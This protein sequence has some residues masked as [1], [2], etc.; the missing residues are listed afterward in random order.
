M[1]NSTPA[2]KTAVLALAVLLPMTGCTGGRD[3]W[4]E[5]PGP[6][7]LAYFPPLYSL[8]ATVAG[9][10]AQVMSLITH[11]GPHHFEPTMRDARC[12]TRADLFLTVGLGL[13]D[14]VSR[15]L[16]DT[17]GNSKLKLV[18][19]GETLPRDS[20]REGGCNCEHGHDHGDHGHYDPHVWLGIP[21]AKRM[22]LAIANELA[23]I[24][25][26]HAAGYRSRA[27]ALAGRLDRLQA[28]GKALLAAKKE[29]PKLLSFHDSLFYFARSFDVEV[30]DSIEAPGQ[31]P[32][33]RKVAQLVETCKK[34]GVRLIAVEPQYPTHTSAR[35]I[36]DALKAAGV[37]AAFVVI[38]PL[39]TADAADLTPDFYERTM[40]GN[41]ERL[42][43]ALQ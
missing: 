35:V 7:V 21:E 14:A 42:A 24:D 43:G 10:D 3:P 8:A 31:E 4:P 20:L 25:P 12:L 15:K 40:R 11:V 5:R 39:E 26:A 13:D 1:T 32:S 41:V 9:D 29:K 28:E 18:A 33:Q 2:L 23:A 16:R 6:K 34:N 30:V 22:T 37:D 19:L 38:D 17:V 36:L 27:E